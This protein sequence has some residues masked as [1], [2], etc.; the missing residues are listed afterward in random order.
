MAVW[1]LLAAA[2]GAWA[3]SPMPD[4]ELFRKA[5]VEEVNRLRLE[6]KMGPVG[7]DAALNRLA[8]EWAESISATGEMKHREGLLELAGRSGYGYLNE[9][10]YFSQAEPTAAGVIRAWMNSQGHRC[11]LLQPRIDRVGLGLGKSANGYYVVFNG[12]EVTR[13]QP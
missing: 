4:Q 11:N 1:F 2:T 12:A 9:N 3:A 5:V 8:S 10:L 13:S 6:N 7:L